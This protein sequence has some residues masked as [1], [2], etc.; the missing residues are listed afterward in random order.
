MS[1]A[2]LCETVTGDT[3]AALIAARDAAVA[4]DLVEVRLDG[5]RNVDVAAVLAGRKKPVIVTC[6][7]AFEGGRFDGSEDERRTILGRALDLGAEFVDVE[8]QAG[9]TDLVARD[10]A[11][12]VLSWHSFD[13]MPADLA[14]RRVRT[15]LG[16]VPL[17]GV[18]AA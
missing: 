3:V 5:V 13:R 9:F 11:R 10:P 18:G 7:A 15:R 14:E 2:L 1:R 6:R 4:G 16:V 12:V 17:E 8:W